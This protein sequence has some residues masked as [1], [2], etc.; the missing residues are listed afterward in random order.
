M[1]GSLAVQQGVTCVPSALVVTCLCIDAK[2]ITVDHLNFGKYLAYVLP[3]ASHQTF[4]N[5][6]S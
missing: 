1:N 5:A 4:I 6:L 2:M 3:L